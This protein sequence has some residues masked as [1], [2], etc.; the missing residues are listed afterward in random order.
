[1]VDVYSLL[2]GHITDRIAE[3]IAEAL[4]KNG[5]DISALSWDID[6]NVYDL[7]KEI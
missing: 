2:D 3:E 6:C 1:M 4:A 7:N 5:Y